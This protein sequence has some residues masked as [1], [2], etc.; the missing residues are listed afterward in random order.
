MF[1]NNSTVSNDKFKL[2]H[3]HFLMFKSEICLTLT[4]GCLVQKLHISYYLIIR[5]NNIDN[6][7]VV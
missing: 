3:L 7:N 4:V 1:I 5:P 2:E 6:L